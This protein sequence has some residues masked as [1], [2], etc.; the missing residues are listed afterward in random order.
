MMATNLRPLD[1]PT[2]KLSWIKEAGEHWLNET[3]GIAVE[4][5]DTGA[6]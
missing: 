2:E 5:L 4:T 6:G 1:A 3:W